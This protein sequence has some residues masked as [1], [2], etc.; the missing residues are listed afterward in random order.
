[1]VIHSRPCEWPAMACGDC[2]ENCKRRGFRLADKKVADLIALL[3]I[4]CKTTARC[5]KE[6]ATLIATPNLNKFPRK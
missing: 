3:G 4:A 1:M 2:R 5:E 6:V